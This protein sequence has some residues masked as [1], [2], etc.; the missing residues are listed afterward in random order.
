MA[1]KVDPTLKI[2]PIPEATDL[3]DVGAGSGDPATSSSGSESSSDTEQPK[4]PDPG[5]GDVSGE[6][7]TSSDGS[8][9]ANKPETESP[10]GIDP[11]LLKLAVDLAWGDAV[12]RLRETGMLTRL[13]E[14]AT[15]D[16]FYSLIQRHLHGVLK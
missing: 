16:W 12:A 4:S 6:K 3:Q 5:N 2:A 13:P 15:S 14:F 7:Y 10:R 1:K 8:Q 9:D 11:Y